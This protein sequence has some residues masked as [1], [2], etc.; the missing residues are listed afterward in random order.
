MEESKLRYLRLEDNTVSMISDKEVINCLKG[1]LP[2]QWRDIFLSKD[3]EERKRK[4]IDL[5]FEHLGMVLPDVTK[6]IRNRLEDIELIQKKINGTSEYCVLYTINDG[7]NRRIFYEGRMPKEV[8][9]YCMQLDCW[10]KLPKEIKAFYEI[11]HN[12]FYHYANRGMGLQPI[13]Y[14]NFEEDDGGEWFLEY[15][16]YSDDYYIYNLSF[17]RNSL[18]IAVSIDSKET[19]TKNAIVWRRDQEPEI[20]KNFWSIVDQL[21]LYF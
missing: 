8:G 1:N 18:G 9:Q 17:F 20:G 2:D 19:D 14:V 11:L 6:K 4:V 21:L 12:G 5:W 15:G 3:K 16:P 13:Q 7:E 10:E